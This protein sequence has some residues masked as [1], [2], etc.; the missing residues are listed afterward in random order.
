M[1]CHIADIFRPLPG[2]RHFKL[3]T[4]RFCLQYILSVATSMFYIAKGVLA[5]RL[6]GRQPPGERVRRGCARAS[7]WGAGGL[8]AE[9]SQVQGTWPRDIVVIRR[10]GHDS[11]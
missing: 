4:A 8:H 7:T 5:T 1:R 9:G 11:K 2:S 3:K 6:P 10:N